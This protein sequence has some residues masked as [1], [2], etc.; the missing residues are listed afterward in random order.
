MANS[1]KDL[2]YK[3]KSQ[4]F[5]LRYNDTVHFDLMGNV[6]VSDTFYE[7]VKNKTNYVLLK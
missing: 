6:C 4:E 2:D 5:T 3:F 1:N 7:K